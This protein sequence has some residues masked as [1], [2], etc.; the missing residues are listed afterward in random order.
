MTGFGDLSKNHDFT[1]LWIGQTI[2][3]LGTRV[4]MFVFPLVT[5]AITG[6]AMLAGIAGGLDLLGHGDRPAAGRTARRPGRPPSGDADGVRGRASSST[7]PW[8]WPACWVSSRSRTFSW[9]AC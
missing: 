1:V 7:R 9:S 2:S 4:S 5:Y 3:E 8:S 6:S